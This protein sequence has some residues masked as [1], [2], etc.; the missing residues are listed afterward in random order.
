MG[1][2]ADRFTAHARGILQ[3]ETRFSLFADRW[4]V[5]RSSTLVRDNTDLKAAKPNKSAA[6]A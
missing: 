1:L 2:T 5:N 4:R 3:V 6:R